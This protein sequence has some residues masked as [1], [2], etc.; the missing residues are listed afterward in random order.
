MSAPSTS[1]QSKTSASTKPP[2]KLHSAAYILFRKQLIWSA[3]AVFLLCLFVS[4]IPRHAWPQVIALAALAAVSGFSSVRLPSGKELVGSP[5]LPLI[6]AIAGLFGA[7]ATVIAAVASALATGFVSIPKEKRLR[8]DLYVPSVTT[9]IVSMGGAAFIYNLLEAFFFLDNGVRAGQKPCLF[10]CL[11]LPFCS[12]FAFVGSVLITTTLANRYYGL[13]WDVLWHEN[14]KWMIS[15]AFLMSP[16]GLLAAIL[17]GQYWWLGVGF[18]LLPVYALRMAFITHQK[19]MEAYRHGV[20]LLGRIMQ[21][22]HPYTHGHLH[23][24]ARWAVQIAEE[25]RLPAAS[26]QHIGDAAILHDIGKVAV[27]DRVLNKVGKLT[28]DDWS[29]IRRH[30]V[31]GADLVVKMS[32]LGTVGH[33]I[34]HHHERPD[35][36]GYPDGLTGDDIP[37]ESSIISVVDAFDAMVGGPAKE[38]QRPY[39]KAI[40]PAEAIAEL[41]RHAG[42]Q[43]REDVVDTFISIFERE[44]AME[45]S[46]QHSGLTSELADDSLWAA[47]PQASTRLSLSGRA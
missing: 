4:P 20:E 34:R 16:V 13:R 40:P 21:E 32:V 26:M 36:K 24:V 7:T 42:T 12:V 5:S 46:G 23:R 38:D 47:P 10:A 35:G 43:F 29:M 1:A 37:V 9:Q 19:S 45:A 39:R 2:A 14:F 27:D 15:N 3:A 31:T 6:F 25:M 22:A 11:T 18:V 44:Q 41:R 30:P 8:L 28:D 17:Y 33:W